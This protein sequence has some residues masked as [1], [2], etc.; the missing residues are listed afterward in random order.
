MASFG[1]NI[2]SQRWEAC[3]SLASEEIPP[4][5]CV[6]VTEAKL[7]SEANSIGEELLLGVNKVSAHDVTS[8][9]EGYSAIPEGY[10]TRGHNMRFNGPVPIRVGGHGY[11]TRSLPAH[12]LCHSDPNIATLPTVVDNRL[13]APVSGQWYLGEVWSLEGTGAFTDFVGLFQ[14]AFATRIPTSQAN[15]S[16]GWVVPASRIQADNAI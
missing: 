4:F 15:C 11:V 5:A 8:N 3:Y 16:V 9:S 1:T 10:R 12:A 6:E 7:A 13:F 2:D 14:M